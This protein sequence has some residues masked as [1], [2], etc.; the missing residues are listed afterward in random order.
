MLC[1]Y[2]CAMLLVRRVRQGM[3]RVACLACDPRI[4]FCSVLL[5]STSQD[6][7]MEHRVA[8]RHRL[9]LVILLWQKM[10][11]LLDNGGTKQP[12]YGGQQKSAQNKKGR[13]H[14]F[15]CRRCRLA[16]YRSSFQ[17]MSSIKDMSYAT[18]LRRSE[19][20]GQLA[21]PIAAV[22]KRMRHIM[23]QE[24]VVTI[25]PTSLPRSPFPITYIY[26]DTVQINAKEGG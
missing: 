8:P 12:A 20:L 16:P 7:H 21:E 17:P 9:I 11:H 24:R 15:L 13:N 25:F 6:G 3:L 5:P 22:S 10:T 14:E 18:L 4:T 26:T 1:A 23:P 19:P 2:C